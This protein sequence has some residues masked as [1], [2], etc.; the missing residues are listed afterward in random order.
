MAI[1][2]ETHAGLSWGS[3]GEAFVNSKDVRR[4]FPLLLLLLA[5]SGCAAL[6]Y[7]IVWLQLLQLVIGSSAVSLGLLLAVYMGG[8]CLG[9]ALLPRIISPAQNPLRIYAWIELGIAALG[10]L[11]LWGMPLVG[12]LYLF[13]AT[14]GMEGI[15]LRGLV[16][17]VCL[18][19]PTL[20]MGASLPAIA[21]GWK[22]AQ[23]GFLC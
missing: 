11:V 13:G 20:L 16:A 14:G 8:L 21:R 4:T 12:R 18:L 9:S 23:P 2:I 22:R 3:S 15:V 7:E 17:S 10:L 6:I 1:L 5:G 19:P